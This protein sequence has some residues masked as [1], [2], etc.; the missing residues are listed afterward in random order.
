MFHRCG[1]FH[2][3]RLPPLISVSVHILGQHLKHSTFVHE[4]HLGLR[5]GE[6]LSKAF[7]SCQSQ[8]LSGHKQIIGAFTLK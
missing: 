3:S 1:K 5:L 8:Q 4:R 6:K 7:D 2:D